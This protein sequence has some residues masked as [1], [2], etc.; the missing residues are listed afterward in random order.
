MLPESGYFP[1][2]LL[3]GSATRTVGILAMIFAGMLLLRR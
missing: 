1:G 3:A 2:A